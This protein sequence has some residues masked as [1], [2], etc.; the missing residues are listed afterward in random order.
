MLCYSWFLLHSV[1]GF[2]LFRLTSILNIN[3]NGMFFFVGIDLLINLVFLKG[4]FDILKNGIGSHYFWF[5]F[6]IFFRIHFS[7]ICFLG[8][9][10]FLLRFRRVLWTMLLCKLNSLRLIQFALL[11]F[12][13]FPLLEFLLLFNREISVNSFQILMRF[14]IFNLVL[15]LCWLR[16]NP[17]IR[18][19]I[20]V[21]FISFTFVWARL[22]LSL[23]FWRITHIWAC[24]YLFWLLSNSHWSWVYF[25]SV[26]S[27][28]FCLISC[29]I[30][31]W[32]GFYLFW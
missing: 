24:I 26:Y 5:C 1:F 16:L 7:N 10:S 11:F 18:L 29:L 32:R 28:I 22:W 6:L 25:S 4:V 2:N 9:L 27:L 19:N 14:F 20:R 31:L 12:L 30:W 15:C 17:Y 3:W 13:F 23:T 21:H 8:G